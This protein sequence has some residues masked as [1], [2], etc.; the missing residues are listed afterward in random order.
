MKLMK[1]GMQVMKKERGVSR[2]RSPRAAFGRLCG[3]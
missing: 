1:K 2:G 3:A